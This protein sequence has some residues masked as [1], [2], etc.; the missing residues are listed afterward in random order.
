MNDEGLVAQHLT[1][2]VFMSY[3]TGVDEDLSGQNILLPTLPI[4][5]HV[6]RPR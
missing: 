5:C 2:K 1:M 4:H 3:K 6:I